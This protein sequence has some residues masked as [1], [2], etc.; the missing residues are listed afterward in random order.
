[1]REDDKHS[2][3]FYE[4][5]Y[6]ISKLSPRYWWRRRARYRVIF[7]VLFLLVLASPLA[8]YLWGPSMRSQLAER[9]HDFRAGRYAANATAFFDAGDLASARIELQNAL[10]HDPSDAASLILYAQTLHKMDQSG[11]ALWA[12]QAY[13]LR[14]DDLRTATLALGYALEEGQ[15]EIADFITPRALRLHPNDPNIKILAAHHLVRRG[16]AAAAARIARQAKDLAPKSPEPAFL[17]ASLSSRVADP[18]TREAALA[19]LRAFREK[20]EYRA[21]AS[22]ALVNAL[23]PA[24]PDAAIAIL[25]DLARADKTAWQA[26]LRRVA[27]THRMNP[28]GTSSALAELWAQAQSPAQ[29]HAI[30]ETAETLAPPDAQ[31]FLAVL[32]ETERNSLPNLMSQ[33]RLWARSKDWRR[34][35]DRAGGAAQTENP[36]DRVLITLWLAKANAELDHE[37]AART[38]IRT[39]LTRCEGNTALCLRAAM[40]LQRLGM[41]EAAI[42]FYGYLADRAPGQIGAFAH[43]QIAL[44]AQSAGGAPAMLQAWEKALIKNP[45]DPQVMNNV[46]SCL[47]L[48]GRDA[49]RALK[50]SAD[51]CAKRPGSVHFADTHAL[52]LASV[53]RIPEALAIHERLPKQRLGQ[54]EFALNYATVLDRAGRRAE[55]VA[56]ASN[57]NQVVLLPEQLA[58]Q[59]QIMGIEEAASESLLLSPAK[60]PDEPA[61]PLSPQK[62][63]GPM[64]ESFQPSASPPLD[65]MPLPPFDSPAGKK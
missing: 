4:E 42:E 23:A 9:Y 32:D 63:L 7:S 52:A 18:A 5:I 40:L 45:G 17:L 61:M 16:N 1:M 57:I 33:F 50:L 2:T 19:E 31:S 13:M 65:L 36:T 55:A 53:G 11:Y 14:P 35:A 21:R 60:S 47:L 56:L 15:T 26:R 3:R 29:R 49:Q 20:P 22:W 24:A 28:S 39:A 51:A 37:D 62:P 38:C 48:L 46:A 43:S 6:G 25:D 10:R 27:L 41:T 12:F 34:I 44:A 58:A 59:R 30:I 8:L 64:P 54:P